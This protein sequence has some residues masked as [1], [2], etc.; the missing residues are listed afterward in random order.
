VGVGAAGVSLT[1]TAS[2]STQGGSCPTGCSTTHTTSSWTLV[3]SSDADGATVVP[4]DVVGWTLSVTNTGPATL[5]GATVTDD[6]SGVLGS[7]TLGVLPAGASVA[8]STLTWSVPDVAPGG[9]VTLD[10]SATVNVGATGATLRNVASPA[11][12]GG[13]C[14]DGCATTTYTPA[15]TLSKSSDAPAVVKPG[16]VITYTLTASNT[17]DGV[18]RGASAVDD[19]ADVLDDATVVATASGLSL[20]GSTLTWAIPTLAAHTTATVTYT[21]TVTADGATITNTVVPSG[22]G[23]T[24]TT[25]STTSW[26]PSWTLAKTSDPADGVAATRAT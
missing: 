24:C 13:S 8:G 21:A 12:V 6:L 25:C 7:A 4:G 22:V 1:N 5:H 18:V 11:S 10:Y 23:G 26:S 15:W 17:S 16:D 14:P 20:D 3:K 19:L 9:T 2:A